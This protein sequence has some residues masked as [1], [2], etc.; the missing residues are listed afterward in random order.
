VEGAET[1]DLGE[2][3]ARKAPTHV[4]PGT[5]MLNGVFKSDR[6]R[7]EQGVPDVHHHV[8]EYGPG[9]GNGREAGAHLPGE[10]R[11]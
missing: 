7:I 3:L 6:G 9:Y 2:Y 11:P 10:Y 1:A 4:A 5:R 8:Y